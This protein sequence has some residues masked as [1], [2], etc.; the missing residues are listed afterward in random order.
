LIGSRAYFIVESRLSAG[1]PHVREFAQWL[2]SE[3]V[4]ETG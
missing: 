2:L 1:K 4:R 3:V